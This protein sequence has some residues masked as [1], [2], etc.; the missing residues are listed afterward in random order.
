MV[1]QQRRAITLRWQRSGSGLLGLLGFVG[2][3]RAQE[4]TVL[5]RQHR[6]LLKNP[7]R[8]LDEEQVAHGG[9]TKK[10]R[11]LSEVS[12]PQFRS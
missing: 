5:R 4:G 12:E 10:S 2:K 9:D 1:S 3:G 6:K 7:V 11:H 8:L